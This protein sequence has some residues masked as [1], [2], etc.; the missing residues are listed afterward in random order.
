MDLKWTMFFRVDG[1]FEQVTWTNFNHKPKYES[2]A[3]LTD[4]FFFQ[5]VPVISG[6]FVEGVGGPTD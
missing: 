2:F 5:S 1:K 4:T 6:R 3:S